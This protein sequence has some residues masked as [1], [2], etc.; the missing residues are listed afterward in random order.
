MQW[1]AAIGQRALFG[2]VLLL[3]VL[4]SLG[5]ANYVR[6]AHL[7][8]GNKP[9]PYK[10]VSDADVDALIEAYSLKRDALAA[11]LKGAADH[12]KIMDGY[13]PADFAGKLDA[14]EAFQVKNEGWLDTNRSRLEMVVELE[15]LE[16]ERQL[17]RQREEGSWA[18]I[19]R[20]VFTF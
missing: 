18:P 7:D 12:S 3:A 5:S 9:R 14:F 2:V 11:R 10:G 13:A 4:G 20:R 16:F 19:F 1:L 15:K 8:E 6:N 17:R